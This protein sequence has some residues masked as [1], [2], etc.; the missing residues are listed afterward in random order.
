MAE[1]SRTIQKLPISVEH[2]HA[3]F[4][5]PQAP[6]R[7]AP[8][9][10]AP[11]PAV[12]RGIT[13]DPLGLAAGPDGRLWFTQ[14][15]ADQVGRISVRGKVREFARGISPDAEPHGIT[16][17]PGGVMW[18]G[19]LAGNRMARITTGA[20]SPDHRFQVH[21]SRKVG[22]LATS[23]TVPGQGWVSSF[24]GRCSTATMA[25]HA[26]T[27]RLVCRGRRLPARQL[28]T[29]TP[30]GGTPRAVTISAGRG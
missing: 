20:A 11:V 16:A 3:W 22:R 19:E 28:V 8:P 10:G 25:M 13:A 1:S 23:V 2:A 29:F 24:G 17:G 12:T 5:R 15:T 26:G 4:A 30:T 9:W 27:V 14:P 7:L 6:G 18:F 21:T